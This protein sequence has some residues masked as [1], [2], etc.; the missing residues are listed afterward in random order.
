M[1]NYTLN[2]SLIVFTLNFPLL[3]INHN[4]KIFQKCSFYLD[5]V[6]VS[7]KQIKHITTTC[8]FYKYCK[9]SLVHTCAEELHHTS[10]QNKELMGVDT[11]EQA[12]DARHG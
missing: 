7:E 11:A 5:T 6:C 12:A 2:P 1:L 10:F 8:H 9:I 4:V 3:I